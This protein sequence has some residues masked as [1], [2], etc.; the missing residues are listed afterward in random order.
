MATGPSEPFF[1][2]LKT[3]AEALR[4]KSPELI[5]DVYL[6]PTD[7]GGKKLTVLPGWGCPCSCSKSSDSLF[8]DGWPLLDEP[9]APGE[10]RRLGFVFLSGNDGAAV[11][12]RAGTFYL[13]EGRF[14]GEATIVA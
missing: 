5:A 1:D 6:Y 11:L 7:D 4:H 10:R 12:R 8:Y 13:W 9:F 2:A 3:R 14:I